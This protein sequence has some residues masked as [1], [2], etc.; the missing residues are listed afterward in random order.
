M[1]STCR[2]EVSVYG[3]LRHR[4]VDQL[5]QAEVGDLH[6]PLTIEQ[7]IL[8]LDV[9]MDDSLLVRELQRVAELRHDRHRLLR[10][11]MPDLEHPAEVRAV[12]VL[13]EEVVP[14]LHL[15]EII[16]RDDVGM[17]QPSQRPRLADEPLLKARIAIDA[18]R[19]DFER[20]QP[21][22]PAMACLVHHPHS[23]APHQFDD[24][25]LGELASQLRH[26]GRGGGRRPLRQRGRLRIV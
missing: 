5:S 26:V 20:D 21:I 17:V 15:P 1:P 3:I 4:A 23:A 16:N 6:P 9:A 18:R 10:R 14:P 11:Q 12:H 8:R 22:E 2:A 19:K 7:D 25:E 13:H 24:F